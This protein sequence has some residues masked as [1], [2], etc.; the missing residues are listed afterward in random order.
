MKLLLYPAIPAAEVQQ[1]QNVSGTL[2]IIN[3]DDFEEAMDAIADADAM[4]GYLK[5]PL[6]ARAARLRWLQ[7]P[8]AGLENYMFPELVLSKL[9]MTNMAG[10]YS[11]MIADHALTYILMFARGFHIYQRQQMSQSWQPTAP[12]IHLADATI[13][14]IGLG[15][16]GAELARRAKALGM[17]VI[18]TEARQRAKPDFL[19]EFWGLDRLNDLLQQADFVVSCVPHTPETVKLIGAPQLRRMKPSAYLIN[20]SRGV[21][22]DLAAL[23]EALQTGVIAG[24]GLDV[25]EIEPLPVD[26]PL[27]RMQN[28]IITPH[29]AAAGEPCVPVRRIGVVAENLRRFLAGE[30]LT[31]IVDKTRW[32]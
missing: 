6:L 29:A 9:T 8:V 18:T 14:V 15:G 30:P 4:Y 13:G 22:V 17:R 1:L 21:V 10:I 5:P 32:F 31:N 11:D 12:V 28:V 25:F 26:H 20:I 24:A 7:S 16:I 19:D 3:T 23:T 2:E 27:W